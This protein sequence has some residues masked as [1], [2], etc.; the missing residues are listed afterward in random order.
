MYHSSRIK[1][2]KQLVP[3]STFGLSRSLFRND[4]FT[5]MSTKT[6]MFPSFS[7]TSQPHMRVDLTVEGSDCLEEI[8]IT[9]SANY[10]P[11]INLRTFL[12]GVRKSLLMVHILGESR[13]SVIVNQINRL[14]IPGA[15]DQFVTWPKL[16]DLLV[17]KTFLNF[18]ISRNSSSELAEYNQLKLMKGVS[19]VAERSSDIEE[20]KMMIAEH[21]SDFVS[22]RYIS[23]QKNLESKHKEVRGIRHQEECSDRIDVLMELAINNIPDNTEILRSAR[24]TLLTDNEISNVDSVLNGPKNQEVLINKFNTPMDRTKLLCLRP[25]TWLNDEVNELVK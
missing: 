2:Q 24:F 14:V 8:F 9:G 5:V 12:T 21:D 11:E 6:R 7:Q 1:K 13:A 3:S 19:D 25:R 18:P 15:G 23:T 4:S 20:H 16:K 22:E 17:D 10:P